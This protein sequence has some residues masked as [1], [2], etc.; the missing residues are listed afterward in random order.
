MLVDIVSA[1][2]DL[3]RM[4]RGPH[5]RL[6]S[7]RT[8]AL[9]QDDQLLSRDP[10][11]LDRLRDD[12]FRH[13]IAVDVGRVPGVQSAI[14]CRFEERERLCFLF[15]LNQHLPAKNTATKANQAN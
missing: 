4:E 9:R 8:K 6:L 12:L 13:A 3:V 11:F 5:P 7:H 15:C 14:V 10:V 2:S 1:L